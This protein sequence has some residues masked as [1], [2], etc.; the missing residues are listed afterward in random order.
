RPQTD[1]A[2]VGLPHGPERKSWASD[3][4]THANPPPYR[5]GSSRLC[6]FRRSRY[7]CPPSFLPQHQIHRPAAPNAWP[8]RSALPQ[9]ISLRAARLLK[10]IGQDRHAIEGAVFVDALSEGGDV[11]CSP[12]GVDREG[13]E[14]VAEH[15]P[16][17][18][19]ARPL[20]L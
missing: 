3:G 16:H 18:P 11:R 5:R 8:A 20:L 4:C 2:Y 1:G 15:L 12:G 7:L 13:A 14:G 19:S 10:R 6:L 9:D 17:Q